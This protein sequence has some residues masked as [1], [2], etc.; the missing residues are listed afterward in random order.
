M[1]MIQSDQLLSLHLLMTILS[2]YLRASILILPLV[3]FTI[4]I[5]IF[6]ESNYVPMAINLMCY[7]GS[8]ILASFDTLKIFPYSAPY[9]IVFKEVQNPAL[10]YLSIMIF[11]VLSLMLGH[12]A[13]RGKEV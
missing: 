9:Y 2:I 5:G 10:P 11:G 7:I 3:Y 8:L 13:L 4:G 1:A 6:T 12:A